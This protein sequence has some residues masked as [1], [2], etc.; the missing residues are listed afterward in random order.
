MGDKRP[1]LP[2][3]K[4]KESPL[5]KDSIRTDVG[6]EL[7]ELEVVVGRIDPEAREELEV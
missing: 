2:E 3:E 5:L 6:A 7:A 1:E 4:A